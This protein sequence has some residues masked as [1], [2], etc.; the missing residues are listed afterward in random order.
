MSE[1]S[2]DIYIKNCQFAY[3]NYSGHGSAIHYCSGTGINSPPFLSIDNCSFTSNG[4]ADSVVYSNNHLLIQDSV[5]ISNQGVPLY[6]LNAHVHISGTVII[7]ENTAK[8]GGGIF[9]THSTIE[10]DKSNVHFYGN[11]VAASGG[12]VY[13]QTSNMTFGLNSSVQFESN[14]ARNKGVIFSQYRSLITFS[15]N[16]FVTFINNTAGQN[17]GA[18]SAA[19]YSDISF[20]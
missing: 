2:E 13:L 19:E 7:R 5:F 11:S 9:S 1:M 6:L 15:N 3:N 12:G 4:P 8:Y 16:S 20:T 14:N 18:I 17:G 10:I